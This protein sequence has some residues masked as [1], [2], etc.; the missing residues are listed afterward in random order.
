MSYTRVF[1]SESDLPWSQFMKIFQ[2]AA[3]PVLNAF[4]KQEVLAN[5]SLV[6]TGEHTGLLIT[7]FDT[8]AKMNKYLKTMDAVR[9]DTS[10]ETGSQTWIYT[11][12]VKASG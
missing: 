12:Q 3:V 7:E 4:K 1:V 5:W 9:R 8:K 6:Q 11:G 10:A 2:K